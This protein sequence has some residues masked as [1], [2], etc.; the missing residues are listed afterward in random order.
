M[1]NSVPRGHELLLSENP[2]YGTSLKEEVASLQK[3]PKTIQVSDIIVGKTSTITKDIAHL[4]CPI[5]KNHV[6]NS[7]AFTMS[8]IAIQ[9]DRG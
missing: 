1:N 8:D 7:L 3:S 4:V 6:G 5:Q 2:R 9:A